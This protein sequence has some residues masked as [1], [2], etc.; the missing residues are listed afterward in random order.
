MYDRLKYYIYIYILNTA[1]LS[2]WL[3]LIIIRRNGITF[4]FKKKLIC[5]Y[6][7]PQFQYIVKELI[8]SGYN[9]VYIPRQIFE[10]SFFN[11]LVGYIIEQVKKKELFCLD[12]Y[13][14]YTKSIKKYEKDL[15][16][17]C[18]L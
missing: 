11:R 18:K 4:L 9:I 12:E 17:I 10:Y 1:L 8:K 7:E 2:T 3:L 5:I 6:Y 13:I 14:K 16:N 15:K